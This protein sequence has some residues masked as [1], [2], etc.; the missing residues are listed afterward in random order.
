M[1]AYSDK[2]LADIVRENHETVRVFEK[3]NLDYCCRGKK[4]LSEAC[5][6]KGLNLESICNEITAA[7]SI[8]SDREVPFGEMS[9]Q[10]LVSHI[11]ARHHYYAKMSMPLIS[12]HL[13][14]VANKHGDNYPYMRE[15]RD[16]FQALQ[17]E[18]LPHLQKEEMVLFP[19]I[20]EWVG[21]GF[22]NAGSARISVPI[23]VMEKEHEKVSELMQKI[24][25]LTNEYIPPTS[26]CTTFRVS[27]Q[28]LK[29][30]EED[31][32]QHVHLENNILFPMIK[33]IASN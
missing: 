16:Q 29:D 7:E 10:Q 27:L 22:S 9:I 31:L 17:E 33:R 19:R 2:T 18:M 6:E 21:T 24:R 25:E 23:A 12:G 5:V 32:H 28:E 26:A 11:I 30:F 20:I 15:V 4:K 1:A 13:D 8:K 14:K 3:Y